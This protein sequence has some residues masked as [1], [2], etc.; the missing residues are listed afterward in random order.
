LARRVL[1]RFA[2][3]WLTPAVLALASC[4]HGDAEASRKA[5]TSN[6]SASA[7]STSGY[8][9]NAREAHFEAE[10]KRGRERWQGKPNVGDC[11]ATLHEKA[12]LVL[13]QAA[14]SALAALEQDPD[15]GAAEQAVPLL[16]EAALALA[17]FSQRVR[18]LSI[19]ELAQKRIAGDAGAPTP[20]LAPTSPVTS[21]GRPHWPLA[22]RGEQ[23]LGHRGTFELGDGPISKMMGTTVHLERDVVRQLGAYLEYAEL[24][25]RRSTFATVKH[26]R[27][28]HPQWPLLTALLREA[29]LLESDQTLKHELDEF[30]K[31]GLPSGPRPA[32]SADSK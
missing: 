13:C 3:G 7:A 2:A 32:H 19:A 8:T 5:S 31:S 27:D 10:L 14:N 15:A 17:R 29:T 4:R 24:P 1:S 20:P 21:G 28:Q 16:A 9:T 11:A 6:A 30:G 12:D 18:F 25:V 26:L 23:R 22:L